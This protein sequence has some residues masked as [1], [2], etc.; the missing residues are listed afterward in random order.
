MPGRRAKS[1]RP[2]DLVWP[3]LRPRG[4]RLDHCIPLGL[5]YGLALS[6]PRGRRSYAYLPPLCGTR[7]G[8]DPPQSQS[9]P[10]RILNP[11]MTMV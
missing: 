1:L 2:P 5:G 6:L 3:T 4:T 7:L 11:F 9:L 8:W 10:Q